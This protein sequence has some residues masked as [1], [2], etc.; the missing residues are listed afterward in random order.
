MKLFICWSGRRGK[1]AALVIAEWLKEELDSCIE[2]VVSMGIEKGVRWAD[3]LEQSLQDADNGLLCITQ[4][5]L[6]SPWVNYEAGVLSRAVAGS[7]G[8]DKRTGRLFTFLWGVQPSE[9]GGPLALFQSTDGRD[10][11]DV[12][13]LVENLIAASGPDGR[14]RLSPERWQP[15][16]EKLRD[17]LELIPAATLSEVCPEFAG[18]FRRKTFEE[19]TY[20][21][22]NQRWLDRYEGAVSTLAAL[23]ERRHAVEGA[24]RGYTVDLYH[25]LE[26]ELA[27]YVMAVSLLVGKQDF[28]LNDHG[29]VDIQPPGILAA[30]EKRRRRVRHVVARLVDPAQ[31]AFFDQAVR[32]DE[33]EEFAERKNLIH[34]LTA[35][36]LETVQDM[37]DRGGALLKD[38]P[39]DAFCFRLMRIC[40][41]TGMRPRSEG[42]RPLDD[43]LR[44]WRTSE[45]TLDRITYSLFLEQRARR[46]PSRELLGEALDLVEAELEKTRAREPAPA[47]AA[48]PL[49]GALHA[50]V[51]ALHYAL[52][53]LRHLP[54]RASAGDAERMDRLLKEVIGFL[55]KRGTSDEP[56]RTTVREIQRRMTDT[57]AVAS[58]RGAPVFSAPEVDRS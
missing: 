7:R 11:G 49:P 8:A 1:L 4:E 27:G 19:P 31:A 29:H 23:R 2:P 21:C 50:P 40:L 47:Q 20:Q 33:A 24:C 12:R 34:E 5:A 32:F 37:E 48:V 28:K 16:W 36:V 15:L 18:L 46:S 3:A 35:A 10:S 26:S 43:L 17:R 30:C 56:V 52:A 55:D 51:M 41:K 6:R 58:Q 45:W 9:L 44:R 13:S 42:G 22:V 57:R 54:A 53:P 14:P 38:W 39:P 25:N